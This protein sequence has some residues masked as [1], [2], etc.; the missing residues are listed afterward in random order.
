MT[1]DDY[2]GLFAVL[3]RVRGRCLDNGFALDAWLASH[4]DA[5]PALARQHTPGLCAPM[6]SIDGSPPVYR[7]RPFYDARTWDK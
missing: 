7:E 2:G 4:P 1:R 5:D 6:P 3:K